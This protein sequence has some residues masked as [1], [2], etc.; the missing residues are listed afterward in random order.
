MQLRTQDA[1]AFRRDL[2]DQRSRLHAQADRLS[3]ELELASQVTSGEVETEDVLTR[4]EHGDSSMS[5]TSDHLARQL[6]LVRQHA[7]KVDAEIEILTLRELHAAAPLVKR[8]LDASLQK[9][10][11]AVEALSQ[12]VRDLLPLVAKAEALRADHDIHASRVRPALGDVPED[13]RAAPIPVDFVG[14]PN[15]LHE[16]FGTDL[17]PGVLGRWLNTAADAGLRK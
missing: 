3:A 15:Q 10:V 4:L 17:W 6:R 12:D 14:L 5:P 2:A 7:A 9:L 16:L 11:T 8:Q 1:N 13:L